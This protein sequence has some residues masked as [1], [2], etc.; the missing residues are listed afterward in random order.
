MSK[1]KNKNR[2]TKKMM[3]EK[4]SKQDLPEGEEPSRHNNWGMLRFGTIKQDEINA[5][6]KWNPVSASD[7][8][9]DVPRY[10]VKNHTSK[11]KSDKKK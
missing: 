9:S 3:P 10:F 4:N 7:N 6:P 5:I 8:I 11:A 1:K 2:K